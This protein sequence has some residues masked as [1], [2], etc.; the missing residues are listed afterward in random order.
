[1]LVKLVL[2]LSLTG[3]SCELAASNSEK[4]VVLV[5]DPAWDDVAGYINHIPLLN[6]FK[7]V[8]VMTRLGKAH[9]FLPGHMT[10]W[11]RFT[12]QSETPDP[13]AASKEI[14][15]QLEKLSIPIEAVIPTSDGA[16]Q[17][18]DQIAACLHKPGNP[19]TGLLGSARRNK[20]VMH[21]AMQNAG[22]RTMREQVV[23]NWPDAKALLDTW[24]PPLSSENPCVFK[25]LQGSGGDGT[26]RI[27]SLDQ[28]KK[29]WA[30]LQGSTD[31]T[32]DVSTEVLVQEFL[33]GKEYAIDS[34]SRNGV[35]KVVAVWMEDFRPAN[36]IFDQYFGMKLMNPDHQKIK[37]IIE[38][39]TQVLDATGLHNGAANTEIKWLDNQQIPCLME[40]NA[41]WAGINWGDGLTAEET[42][43]GKNIIEA[44]FESYLDKAAFDAMP[45]V[46]PITCHSALIQTLNYKAGFLKAIPGLDEVKKMKTYLSSDIDS[47]QGLSG[48][49]GK[50]L[51]LTSPNNIP[52]NIALKSNDEKEVDADYDRIIQMEK[53]NK[54]FDTRPS[55]LTESL[56][57]NRFLALPLALAT[58]IVVGLTVGMV[59]GSRPEC[60]PVG[61]YIAID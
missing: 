23:T 19:S 1:M 16:V 41:R 51:P 29:T 59:Y 15:P 24:N 35:H 36:G 47:A 27:N 9:H 6:K 31:A 22:L 17:L 10:P 61:H 28:A 60:Q 44:A 3:C 18:T 57:T 2:A 50:V 7:I 26:V 38:Y 12:Y 48:L 8:K 13:V 4:A 33:V 56:A 14:C 37:S 55:M 42:C 54:F 49:I 45:A 52:V 11:A 32:G 34:V 25:I 20:W 5:V 39:G 43:T 30:K 40:I 58:L 21:R 46:R 53:E